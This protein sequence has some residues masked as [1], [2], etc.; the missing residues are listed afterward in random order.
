[1]VQAD[2]NIL[3]VEL[4]GDKW[5]KIR[6][7][8]ITWK[9]IK[10]IRDEMARATAEGKNP[11]LDETLLL[12]FTIET[13]EIPAGDK[14]AIGRAMDALGEEDARVAVLLLQAVTDYL[15]P[16]FPTD[17]RAMTSV[18]EMSTRR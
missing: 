7:R 13:S 1:M 3:K 15:F 6:I 14:E 9:E 12:N 17:K 4:P 5:W 10:A 2:D 11:D 8:G 18:L 16:L